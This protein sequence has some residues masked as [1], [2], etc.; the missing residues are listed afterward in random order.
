MSLRPS[1]SRVLS[2]AT[3][4]P[5]EDIASFFF[6]AERISQL[7][8]LFPDAGENV[9]CQDPIIGI[10]DPGK[11]IQKL[12]QFSGVYGSPGQAIGGTVTYKCVGTQWKEES[13]AC[14]SAPINGLLQVAKVNLKPWTLHPWGGLSLWLSRILSP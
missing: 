10:G 9:T 6:M 12:C 4:F 3:H 11:V 8:L 14:I 1:V 5:T 13:R 2:S 7:S